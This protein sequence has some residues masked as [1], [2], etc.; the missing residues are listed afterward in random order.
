M[1]VNEFEG[2]LSWGYNPDYYFAPDKYYG[3]KNEMKA[4]IDS[5][6][7]KGIAVVMDIA[8]NHSFG[9]SPM[10]QMYFDAVNN[11]P[12]SNNPWFNTVTKH[13]FN[14]G[15]DMNHESLP[16]RYFTSRVIEHWLTEYKIDG[17]RFDLSKGFT[18]TQTCDNNGA[19]CD[20]GA[21]G[22]YDASR[23][24]IWKRYYDT[25]Q[26]KSPGCYGILEHFAANTEEIELSNYGLM[27]WGNMNYNFTEAAMGYV[28]TSNFDGALHV[29][30]GWSQPYL[31]SYMES[32]DEERMMYKTLQFGNS[33]GAYNTR[34]FETA[35]DRMELSASFLLT[36]PGPKMIWQFGELG[37]DYSINY[38]QDGSINNN[39]RT[40]AKPIKWDY[41][42]VPGRKDLHDVYK[43]LLQLR[44]N[45]LFT[46][47][48][49]TGVISRDFTSG[50][51]W[52][53]L[54]SSAGKLVVIGNFDVVPQGGSVTFPAAGTWYDYLK[55]PL[56]FNATGAAQVFNLQPGEYHV[57]LSSNVVV[58]VALVN[59]SGKNNGASNQLLWEVENEVN[60]SH[61][62]LERSEDAIN[63]STLASI[64]A[65][66]SR[67]YNYTDNDIKK[68]LVYFYR[69]KKVDIDGRF[70]YSATLRLSGAVKTISIAATPNPFT[71]TVFVNITSPVKYAATLMITDLSGRQL[72]KQAVRLQAG[73]NVIEVPAGKLS[74]GSYL[75]TMY[76]PEQTTSIRILKAK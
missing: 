41:L 60:L 54:N 73:V 61:Y 30:R 18:Q 4:F 8:L 68:L 65:T 52:M 2:N 76:S 35:L 23:I 13:A 63:F 59:F 42:Q 25:L 14:V 53:T 56:T 66:G 74:A 31:V 32:H 71:Q 75:L 51:K 64:T 69:L 58:P 19:N 33:S 57:Y 38:C 36:I 1:P 34:S 15:Y 28:A 11:R 17:F 43:A 24:A 44:N 5:C 50:F 21:M 40:D 26:L 55:Q 22:N 49:T 27:L 70:T 62:E 20:E 6:H 3:P 9:L 12:A 37:Y 48:F 72:L 45:S 39:C 16:T 10:V 47:A 67:N 46:E 29:S 7:K